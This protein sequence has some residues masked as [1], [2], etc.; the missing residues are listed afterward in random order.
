MSAMDTAPIGRL[1]T[2]IQRHDAYSANVPP[3]SGP[4]ITAI[5]HTLENQPCTAARSPTE[6]RSPASVATVAM[7]APAPGPCTPRNTMSVVMFHASAQAMDPPRKI[8]VPVVS[9]ALRPN[10]SESLP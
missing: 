1:I 2:K 8:S 4:A 3:R 7:I 10:W 6:Y 9:T 5:L